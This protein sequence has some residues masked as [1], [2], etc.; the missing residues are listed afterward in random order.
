MS[1]GP[2][3]IYYLLQLP[4]VG[5]P[6]SDKAPVVI[7]GAGLTGLA[8]AY[9]LSRLRACGDPT[10][11]PEAGP[12]AAILAERDNRVGGKAR[13]H[14]REGHTFDVTGH[15]LHLRDERTRTWLADLFE[16][17]AW[18]RVSRKTTIW[19]HGTEL[20]YPFQANLH[21]LPLEVVQECLVGFVEAQRRAAAGEIAPTTFEEYAISQFGAGIS[22]YF[23]V[24]YNSKLWG[25]HPNALTADWVSRFIP[26]PDLAQVIGGAIGLRQ[27]GL[28]Y[29]A[30]FKYPVAGGIDH[31]PKALRAKVEA[32]GAVDLRLDSALEEVDLKGRRVKLA[33]HDDWQPYSKLVSTIPLPEL[34]KRIQGAPA[35]I[36]EAA[37]A[38]RCVRWRYLDLATK[39]PTPRPW[40]W[41]YVPE[42]KYPFFRVG[43]YS[44]AVAAMAP[45]D[46]SS[47]YVELN[48]REGELDLK[49]VVAGLVDMGVL[50]S[51]EDVRF[52]EERQIEYAYVVFD[53]AYAEA[54]STLH[55]WLRQHEIRSCGR[56]G[57]WVYNSME[58]SMIEGMDAADWT[59]EA[60]SST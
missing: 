55:A 42:T 40:H 60:P 39:K 2:R 35:H 4:P 43:C 59:R 29:N 19:S 1:R 38:L 56:Y 34:I 46:A 33:N 52:A 37:A 41:A 21:G 10:G 9:S 47:L 23:F 57:S 45:A 14:R 27:E 24:P 3:G 16:P 36:R 25:M 5:S 6:S 22:K 26:V 15:W 20:A 31:L 18:T 7:L 58:D 49:G 32:D 54:T 30:H 12:P 44:N 28:G 50:T 48:D 53:D 13:S 17:G 51:A 11:A 8:C